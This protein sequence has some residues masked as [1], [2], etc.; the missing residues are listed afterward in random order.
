MYIATHSIHYSCMII[1]AYKHLSTYYLLT[2]YGNVGY[3][4]MAMFGEMPILSCR[5]CQFKTNKSNLLKCQRESSD[6]GII[7]LLQQHN[8]T[9]NLRCPSFDNWT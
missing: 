4:I 2:L 9:M 1:T 8:L 7:A 6:V 5:Y 3:I